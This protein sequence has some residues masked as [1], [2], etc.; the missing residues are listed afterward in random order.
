MA[1]GLGFLFWDAAVDSVRQAL[2]ASTMLGTVLG[3]L[4][5]AGASRLKEAVAPLLV[6]FAVT[7]L[8]VM[9]AL[10]VVA[11]MM[12]P[13]M[14]A[15]VA[16]RR[17]PQLE[18]KHGGS[19]LGSLLW[20]LGST[21]L[22]LLAMLVSM[23]LWLVPPLILLLPP[24]IWGWLTYRVLAFD[25]LASHASREER[26][27]IFRQH[28]GSLLLMGVISGFLGAAPSLLWVSGA[29]FAAAF[30]ILLPLAVWVYTLVFA[31][32]SLWFAHFCLAALE[33]LR[34]Q[35]VSPSARDNWP[36]ARPES[37]SIAID[38]IAA[39]PQIASFPRSPSE[40]PHV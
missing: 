28:R 9:L 20:S 13:A 14:V 39:A 19:V 40:P 16:Q 8:L 18:Q 7:P 24:L 22:A 35:D 33:R 31:F 4:Q 6:I 30:V 15:M 29:V 37:A 26:R 17:F 23:L 32:S 21:L 36:A 27:E 11:W 34:R 3:W 2:D 12:T 1:W 5:S 38:S 10:L 25:A